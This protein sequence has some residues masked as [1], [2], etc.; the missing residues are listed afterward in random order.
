MWTRTRWLCKRS[1]RADLTAEQIAYLDAYVIEIE[2][3]AEPVENSPP[4]DEPQ[5]SEESDGDV[6]D[7]ERKQDQML[8]AGKTTFA[9]LLDW[10]VPA[11]QIEAI[12]GSEIPNR[13]MLVY[14]YCTE[15]G[16]SFGGIK[17][18]LQA[19]VDKLSP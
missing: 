16:L 13:L 12:L 18:E 7:I 11:E 14:D 4:E 5:T 15:N 3:D 9:D 17:A 19:E 2:V 8:V 1:S 10:G 6:E